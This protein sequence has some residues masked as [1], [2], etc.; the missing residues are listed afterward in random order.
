[1]FDG[2]QTNGGVPEHN[3]EIFSFLFFL[4]HMATTD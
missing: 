3:S 4:A 2:E 1:M